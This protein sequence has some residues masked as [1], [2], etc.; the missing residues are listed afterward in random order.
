MLFFGGGEVI[1]YVIL[2]VFVMLY[3]SQTEVSVC[4]DKCKW[5]CLFLCVEQQAVV[6]V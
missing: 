6:L 1:A 4:V 2:M 5:R 3:L